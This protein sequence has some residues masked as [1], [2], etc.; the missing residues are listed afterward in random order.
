M[1]DTRPEAERVLLERIRRMT[2]AK[3]LEEGLRASVTCRHVI[4]AGIRARHPEYSEDDVED[5]LAR[6]LWGDA[7]FRAAKPQSPL[8]E[9]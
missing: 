1:R 2:P 7:L 6:T 9:P 3:R 8:L 4:R 5:A